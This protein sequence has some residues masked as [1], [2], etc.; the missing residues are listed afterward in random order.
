MMRFVCRRGT[1]CSGNF[2]SSPNMVA[3]G[4][5]PHPRPLPRYCRQVEQWY[6]SIIDVIEILTDSPQPSS[7]WNKVKKT[8]L[9][10]NESLRFWQRLNLP[11][12]H[13]RNYPTDC[14]HT[15]GVII[16]PQKL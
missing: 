4:S 1:L 15:E 14:V 8:I 2:K 16:E 5:L 6:F 3:F 7:Y 12:L 13:G 10:E 9:K 11:R